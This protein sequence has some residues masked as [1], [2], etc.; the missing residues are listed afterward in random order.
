MANGQ[1]QTQAPQTQQPPPSGQTVPAFSPDGTLGDIPVE[2]V[3]DAVKAGFKL[4]VDLVSPYCASGVI[5]VERVQDALQKGFK[6]PTAMPENY[7]FTAGNMAGQAWQGTKELVGGLY[8][9]GK[10][11]LFPDGA[12]EGEKLRWLANKYIFD[13]AD[14]QERKAQKSTSTLESIGHSVAEA[15]PL[16][17]PWAASLGEQAGTG[18][19]GGAMARGG[20]QV[21]AAELGGKAIKATKEF[22]KQSVKGV[23]HATGAGG[24]EPPEALEKAG[25]P[26]V[27]ERDFKENAARA[28]P[29]IIE[30]NKLEPIKH[31]ESMANPQHS[32]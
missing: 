11:V 8:T 17:G 21:A 31:P 16:V 1:T 15:I 10:D 32:P 29:R 26:A 6:L 3:H 27:Y 20:T 24:F 9:M 7:G 18:D 2:R 25:R 5:P 13:P 12:T 30:E 23:A 14:E 28:L 19:V 22:V 4:G